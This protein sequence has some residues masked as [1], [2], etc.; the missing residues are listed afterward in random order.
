MKAMKRTYGMGSKG[1]MHGG[2]YAA[3]HRANM[4]TMYMSYGYRCNVKGRKASAPHPSK[5]WPYD[6][7]MGNRPSTIGL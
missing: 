2:A 1:G 6:K 3:A 4:D 5:N 7:N